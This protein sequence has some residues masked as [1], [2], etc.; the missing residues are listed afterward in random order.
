MAG[1]PLGGG[2]G[3]RATLCRAAAS[4]RSVRTA[5]SRAAERDR[6]YAGW[7]D[8]VSTR[9]VKADVS[10]RDVLMARIDELRLMAKV[11]A[12]YHGA[13]LRQVE[14]TERLNIHQST[15]S[16]LLQR[17]E[18]EGIVRVTFS[19][20]SGLHPELEDALQSAFGLRE[21]VVVDAI[22][23]E[24]QIVRD[25]GAAAAFYLE[26]TL[27]PR[28]VVGIRPGARRFSRWSRRCTDRCR[29]GAA[30]VSADAR[31]SGC[32]KPCDRFDARLEP[33][34][35]TA[36]LCPAP[37]PP[38]RAGRQACLCRGTLRSGSGSC[39]SP[40]CRARRD[41][42]RRAI[43][44]AATHVTARAEIV[45][46]A[47][48]CGRHCC[49]AFDAAGEPVKTAL[50]DRVISMGGQLKQVRRVVGSRAGSEDG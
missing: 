21:A 10:G 28:D 47:R 12:L 31:E 24:D 23:A 33:V 42:R 13:G 38:Y 49:P 41:R 3:R 18:R 30:A 37:A 19:M 35:C 40:W 22:D 2:R 48:C 25:L 11:A 36:M 15:V 6:R 8:A 5:L 14:I 17:A 1:G 34:G 50:I 46:R 26:T 45:K 39:S 7:T 27:K 32:G 16:R 43:E 44:P 20:P 29:R 4:D 9:A